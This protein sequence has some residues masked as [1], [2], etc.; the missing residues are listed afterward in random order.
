MTEAYGVALSVTDL[1]KSY[2]DLKAVDGI[3]FAVR[4]AE[5][6]GILGP[7]GAGK[8]TTVECI[9]GLRQPDSGEIVLLGR[10]FGANDPQFRRR[11][12][13]QLQST[14]LYPKL[15]VREIIGLFSSFYEDTMDRDALLDLVGLKGRQNAATAKLSGGQAQ[16]LSLALALV[17]KPEMVFL[18]EPSTGLDPQARRAIWDIV[19]DLRNEGR[20]VLLTTHYMEEAEE[21]CDRVAVMDH[22]R[23][24]ELGTPRQLIAKYFH[25]TAIEVDAVS[26]LTTEALA[27]LPAVNQVTQENGRFVV[28][29]AAVPKTMSGLFDWAQGQS[30]ELGQLVVRQATL[31]DV[32]LKITGR[33]IR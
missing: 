8:T 29:S 11:L 32:F 14:G 10:P 9:E 3:S 7:N 16:R 17:N 1:R 19:K 12:G 27:S 18:D 22:G 26:G 31:E 13:I 6:F 2:G 28:F 33:R 15:T 24:I 21:L 4:R 30:V 23:I 5:V 20:T 25:E